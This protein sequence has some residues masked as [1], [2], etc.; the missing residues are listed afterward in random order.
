[1]F[2]IDM[3]QILQILEPPILPIDPVCSQRQCNYL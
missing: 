3:L 2:Y 1:M